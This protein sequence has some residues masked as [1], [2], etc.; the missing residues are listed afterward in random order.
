M[1]VSHEVPRGLLDLSLSFNDYDYFLIHQI[2]KYP[3]YK[4][5]FER[6]KKLGRRQILDN[7]LYEL[8]ESFNPGVFAE[9]VRVMNPSEY[10]IPDCFN[11]YKKNIEMFDSWMREH[12]DLPGVKI[13]TVHGE[14]IEE[15][16]KAYNY[17]RQFD[18]KIAFNFAESLYTKID[19]DPVQ[20]RFKVIS[21]IDI[22]ESKKHH[23][24]GCTNASEFGLYV[25]FNWI[26]TIDTSNPIMSAFEC[27]EY[28]I[29]NKP[30]T[31]VDD[32]Q[33]MI[34]TPGIRERILVNVNKFKQ[35]IAK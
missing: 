17:F 15:F 1:L 11:N 32:T 7:S 6:S 29:A 4:E 12:Y 25:K 13:A 5:F 18:V 3:E 23:L 14:S 19:P 24:L 8:K 27:S 26:E 10:L 31:A 16:K 33:D 22:D 28:P 34:I 20:G 30:K 35:I 21:N 2:V 9:Y